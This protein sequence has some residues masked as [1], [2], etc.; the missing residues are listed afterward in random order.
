MASNLEFI[1]SRKHNQTN[2]SLILNNVFSS[3]MIFIKLITL[4]NLDSTDDNKI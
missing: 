2:V 4:L 3:D 1:T